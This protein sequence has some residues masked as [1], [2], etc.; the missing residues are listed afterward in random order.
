MPRVSTAR[1]PHP[2]ACPVPQE[3]G[4][5][6]REHAS[7][8]EDGPQSR[9]FRN[10]ACDCHRRSG[11]G[12]RSCGSGSRWHGRG[13]LTASR[14][15]VCESTIGSRA[16]T[17]LESGHRHSQEPLHASFRLGP[18]GCQHHPHARGR[19]GRAGWPPGTRACPWAWPRRPMCSG[20]GTCGT[21]PGIRTGRTATASC[22][23]PDT[24]RCC[25][26]PCCT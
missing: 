9:R 6:Y 12:N 20:P 8:G 23:A 4:G 13:R 17:Q 26:M 14:H 22:S 1:G 15:P 25:S 5:A 18:Q 24:D 7:G 19:L 3:N 21:V 16:S 11:F 10:R 2:H